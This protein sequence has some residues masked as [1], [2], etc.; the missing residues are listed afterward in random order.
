MPARH[1]CAASPWP[2]WRPALAASPPLPHL[3]NDALQALV[4]RGVPGLLAWSATLLA[5][6][7]FFAGRLRRTRK[8]GAQRAAAV[9]GLSLVLA[10]AGF[11]LAEAIFR[12]MQASLF[13]A[14]TV[15][16]LMGW[17]L[18]SEYVHPA[19][20]EGAAARVRGAGLR[21]A[22]PTARRR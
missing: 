6:L 10:Y 15:F 9:A 12:S 7:A 21:A 3:H 20:D 14:L 16:L 5:P 13:Y 17:C 4:T 1:R 18:S 22:P 2:A 11:S 8:G 19:P